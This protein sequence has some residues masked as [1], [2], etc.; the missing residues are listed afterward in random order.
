MALTIA[1]GERYVIELTFAHGGR[2]GPSVIALSLWCQMNGKKSY[3]LL[4]M[5]FCASLNDTGL[6]LSYIRQFHYLCSIFLHR[7][8]AIRLSSLREELSNFR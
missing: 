8:K 6:K 3:V 4:M 1:L 5:C 7:L 2:G